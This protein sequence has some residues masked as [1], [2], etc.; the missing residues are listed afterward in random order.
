MLSQLLPS[1]N[2]YAVVVDEDSR[3]G[4][5]LQWT[6]DIARPMLWALLQSH[7]LATGAES[8]LLVASSPS[9]GC[10]HVRLCELV[11]RDNS[12]VL[13]VC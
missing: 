4:A 11:Q 1:S 13:N 5:C 12:F 2:Q 7:P 8:D 3:A 6:I 9:F 10:M